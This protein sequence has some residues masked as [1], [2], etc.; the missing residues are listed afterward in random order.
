MERKLIA[1]A[2]LTLMIILSFQLAFAFTAYI[3]PS[4]II[5]YANVTPGAVTTTTG[6]LEIA[7][8]NNVSVNVEFTPGQN[9]T[10]IVTFKE[11]PITLE[12]NETR[13]VNFEVEVTQPGIYQDEILVVYSSEI[14]PDVHMQAD[15]GIVAREVEKT[16]DYTLLIAVLATGIILI[17]YLI[18]KRGK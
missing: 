12:S 8:L 18:L 13:M 7:N 14:F 10:N 11:N 6:S 5:L 3:R 4:R 15:V 1:L 17:S 2:S 9:L 16:N